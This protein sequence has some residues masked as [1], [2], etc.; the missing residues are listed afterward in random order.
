[1]LGPRDGDILGNPGILHDRFFISGRDAG[2]GF[3]LVEHLLR[4]RTAADG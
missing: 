1:M 2:G 3:S 4:G